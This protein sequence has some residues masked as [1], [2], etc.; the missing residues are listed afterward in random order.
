MKATYTLN[1]LGKAKIDQWLS[2]VLIEGLD[3]TNQMYDLALSEY[4]NPESNGMVYLELDESQSIEPDYTCDL[5]GEH[6]DWSYSEDNHSE[7][8]H[9]ALLMLDSMGLP[10][11]HLSQTIEGDSIIAI[12]WQDISISNPYRSSCG[13]FDAKPSD[14]GITEKQA[15]AL[16]KTNAALG[17]D[18][19]DILGVKS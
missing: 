1:A 3:L 6:F 12:T 5:N 14:Y 11:P 10:N 13:R 9:Y 19:D 8:L 18:C 16:F 15:N 2:E 7:P 4:A 17:F